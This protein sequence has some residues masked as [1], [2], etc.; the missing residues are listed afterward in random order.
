[1][2]GI[3]DR[4]TCCS[5]ADVPLDLATFSKICDTARSIDDSSTDLSTRLPDNQWWKFRFYRTDHLFGGETGT[6]WRLISENPGKII[7]RMQGN[8]NPM[9]TIAV[10]LSVCSAASITINTT[11]AV[12]VTMRSFRR[13]RV[14]E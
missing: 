14:S 7:N 8:V 3:V 11:V 6:H 12:A 5:F 10:Y 13:P 1:M 9:S 2:C 4:S